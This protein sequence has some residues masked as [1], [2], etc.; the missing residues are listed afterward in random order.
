M[1]QKYILL[2]Y[3]KSLVTFVTVVS[4][5]DYLLYKK[6]LPSTVLSELQYSGFLL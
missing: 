6:K 5:K 1:C 2:T 3:F 4:Y